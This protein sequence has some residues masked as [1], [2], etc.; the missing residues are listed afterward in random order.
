MRKKLLI[1]GALLAAAC[2][3][4]GSVMVYTGPDR[5]PLCD[6]IKS[7]APCLVNIQTGEVEEM[8][9]YTPHLQLVGEIAED[10][11]DSTFSFVTIAGAK[12]TRT[13]SPYIMELDVPVAKEPLL[14]HHF[15]RGCRKLLKGHGGYVIADLYEPGIPNIEPLTDG[16]KLE[17]RCYTI[18]ADLNAF[19][20]EY[21][22]EVLG[23]YEPD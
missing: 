17:I 23:T 21:K 15:C 3:L 18:T 4:V 19:G 14:K 5:C 12:G 11:D 1:V 13:S 16:M 7:H 9:L 8:G 10:Q 20:D 2:L 22:L 6:F